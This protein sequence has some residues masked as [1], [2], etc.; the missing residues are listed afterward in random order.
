MPRK[1]P[2][3]PKLAAYHL[4]VRV[5]TPEEIADL[6]SAP[7]EEYDIPDDSYDPIWNA[8]WECA[9]EASTYFTQR[10]A[11][12]NLVDVRALQIKIED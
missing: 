1:A 3:L 12:R 4:V 8:L 9:Q 6:Y 11:E 5:R 10:L 7:V 2:P